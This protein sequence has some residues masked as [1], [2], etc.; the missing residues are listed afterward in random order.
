MLYVTISI[1]KQI[2]FNPESVIRNKY[3]LFLHD[4]PAVQVILVQ[5]RAH[6]M[7]QREHAAAKRLAAAVVCSTTIAS[8]TLIAITIVDD[9]KFNNSALPGLTH[10]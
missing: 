9:V 4:R 6:F 10:G 8:R 2:R 1:T 5:H 7:Y 3:C